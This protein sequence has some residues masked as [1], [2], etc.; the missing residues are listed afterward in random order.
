MITGLRRPIRSDS[1]PSSGQPMIQ[2]NGTEAER[3]TATRIGHVV[4]LLEEAHAPD[5]VEDRRRDEHQPGDQA[6]QDRLRVAEHRP[7]RAGSVLDPVPARGVGVG[8]RLPG[9]WE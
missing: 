3:S 8:G 2:P 7:H 1:Q 4:R 9:A 6:A 5:H